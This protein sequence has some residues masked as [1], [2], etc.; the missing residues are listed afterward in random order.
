MEVIE[1]LKS[2]ASHWALSGGLLLVVGLFVWLAVSLGPTWL[3]A[4]WY[5]VLDAAVVVIAAVVIVW[6]YVLLEQQRVATAAANAN[7]QTALGQTRLLQSTNADLAATV[8]R[9][10]AAAAA[11]ASESQARARAA[12]EAMAT[13][14]KQGAADGKAIVSLRKRAADPKTNKGTCDEEIAHLRAAR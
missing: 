6:L 1:V 12:S 3:L 13:A 5:E 2:V 7:Y 4:H 9:Q 14:Q 8:V 11:A 10:S